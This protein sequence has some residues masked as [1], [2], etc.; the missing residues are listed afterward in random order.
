MNIYHYT[1]NSEHLKEA[2]EFIGYQVL[3]ILKFASVFF[4]LILEEEL[5]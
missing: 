3:S 2:D 5:Q 4:K 1:T